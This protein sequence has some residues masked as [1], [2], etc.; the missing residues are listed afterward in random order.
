MTTLNR[1]ASRIAV[2]LGLH[3]ACDV[4]GFGLLGHAR[5]MAVASGV[6]MEI[7]MRDVPL[8]EGARECAHKW[9]FP[10]GSFCNRDFYGRHVRF[11]D[12][13]GEEMQMLLFDAQTSG[14]LL[15]AVPPATLQGLLDRLKAEGEPA[16][17][18]GRA[19]PEPGIEIIS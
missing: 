3:G 19:A 6:G 14:G 7:R 2:G 1:T 11:A 9:L 16:W 15:L 8:M 18:I 13:I 17:V 5:E 4:T 10:R 12:G